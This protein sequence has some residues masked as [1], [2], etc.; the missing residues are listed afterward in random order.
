MALP[1]AGR[2]AGIAMVKA[3]TAKIAIETII[4]FMMAH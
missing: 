1:E 3:P 2:I 4:P